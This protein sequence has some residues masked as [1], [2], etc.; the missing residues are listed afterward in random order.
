MVIRRQPLYRPF[1]SPS[2][3][4]S[5]DR[6]FDRLSRQLEWAVRNASPKMDRKIEQ[7]DK[8]EMKDSDRP[9]Q[10]SDQTQAIEPI[11]KTKTT[12]APIAWRPVVELADAGKNIELRFFLPGVAAENVDIQVTKEAVTVSGDRPAPEPQEGKKV[13]TEFRYGRFSRT[14]KLPE[15]VVNNQAQA[16]FSQRHPN[17]DLAEGNRSL[18]RQSIS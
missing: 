14:I 12:P 2:M 9:D 16:D 18:K 5:I 11:S 17:P 13:W 7:P 6:E 1:N 15:A 8:T 3:F 10:A 4:S